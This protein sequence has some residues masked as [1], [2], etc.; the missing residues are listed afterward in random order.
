MSNC[1]WNW[2]SVILIL[3]IF[4]CT[5]TINPNSNKVNS[6]SPSNI[7]VKPSN[8][9][10]INPELPKEIDKP[11]I[12]ILPEIDFLFTGDRVELQ[13]IS[14]IKNE[15]RKVEVSWSSN[16]NKDIKISDSLE[17]GTPSKE[18]IY[19]ITATDINDKSLKTTVKI[20]IIDNG[21]SPKERLIIQGKVFD[22]KNNPIP[23]ATVTS[24]SLDFTPNY[25][26]ANVKSVSTKTKS[27]GSYIFRLAPA[28]SFQELKV[29]KTGWVTRR[30][31][32]VFKSALTGEP[33]Q[34]VY[35]FGG[36]RNGDNYYYFQK[37]P[38]II[39][40][41]VND[42]E[43]L[44]FTGLQYK[45]LTFDLF[46]SDAVKEDSVE[47]NL[48]LYNDKRTLTSN[49]MDF[50]WGTDRKSV[51][52]KLKNSLIFDENEKKEYK[53]SFNKPF[54]SLKGILALEKSY[55]F[56]ESH[57]YPENFLTL[58]FKN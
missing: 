21:D 13:A 48:I 12:K 51:K 8:N 7:D 42:N 16:L 44:S 41:K 26:Y 30:Q 31:L 34:N 24:T 39:R 22:S 49:L 28:G 29:E 15:E 37:E 3:F 10:P 57:R 46:F 50:E 40:I 25:W 11:V 18:G 17:I 58:N 1:K 9:N 14:I 52:V 54:E 38:Q 43:E 47:K 6:V 27:D 4:S 32:A 36:N 56:L 20:K 19:E 35:D 33:F 53:I 2:V 23:D 5:N 55:F 45:N